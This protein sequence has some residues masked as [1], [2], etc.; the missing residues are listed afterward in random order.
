M[1]TMNNE[2]LPHLSPEII[3]EMKGSYLDA[4]VV[5]LEG[6]RRGLKLKWHHKNSPDFKNMKTWFIDEPG[7]IFSL[8]SEE[9]SHYF[10]RTRGDKVTNEAVELGM[11]KEVTKQILAKA[12]I[13]VPKGKQFSQ[14]D[15][16]NDMLSFAKEI[17]YPVVL[18][19]TDGSFG[20]GVFTNISREQELLHSIDYIKNEMNQNN[21]IIEK[22]IEGNDY[23]LYVVGNQVVGAILRMPP[24]VVGD[25][26]NTIDSLIEI[27]NNERNLNPR[28]LS[29]PIVVDEQLTN[30][31]CKHQYNLDTVAGEGEFI[32][33][34]DKC[35]ISLGGDPVDVL[36]DLSE[37]VKQ[38]AVDTFKAIDG[39]EH[40][41][42]DIMIEEDENGKQT[43]YVIEFNPTAQIGGI[44]F[45]MKGKSRD[46]PAAIIDYYFPET[47]D[48]ETEREKVYFDFYDVLEPLISGQ[49]LV[50]T[51]TPAPLGKIHM[52]KYTVYGEVEDTGYHMGLRKQAFERGLHGFIAKGKED[53]I[54]EIV[55]A[56]T[57]KEMVDD[58]LHGITE[59]EERANVLEI[60][61]ETY[62]KFV[63]VGFDPRVNV[64]EIE[65]EI[66]EF[67]EEIEQLNKEIKQL[68]VRKRKKLRSLSWL[69]TYPIRL[70]GAVVKPFKR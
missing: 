67:R 13:A 42:V 63:K 1:E 41:A 62:E 24:N 59:D 16:V 31:I 9:R 10:F 27:K 37:D 11:D 47:K 64:R 28:L 18:K 61:Q 36:D 32:Y 56:G 48:I 3:S 30:F 69:A 26:V 20:R 57:D 19:P 70:A 53:G 29:C 40:G 8:H 34:S 14:K 15:S 33:L 4:Y 6:W 39:F 2:W 65:E 49:G 54:I 50:S 12:G 5:A 58:F 45:P 22:H 44:L 46:I 66:I 43:P 55:V 68:E 7:Q 17:G 35:N 38:F 21:F 60:Q 52:K 51:V 23:R 25:G